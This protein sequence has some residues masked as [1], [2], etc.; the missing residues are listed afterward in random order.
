MLAEEPADIR[1]NILNKQIIN[2]NKDTHFHRCPSFNKNVKNLYGLR[3]IYDYK[4]IFE[5]DKIISDMYD[6]EFFDRMIEI[7]S[8][9]NRFFS[10]KM[11]YIFFTNEPSLEVT[12]YQFPF[13]EDNDFTKKCIILPGTFDIG[14][15]FR[16][17]ELP[18]IMR[19]EFNDLNIKQGDIYSYIKF[20]TDEKIKFKQ[21]RFN[22][23]LHDYMM[24]GYN[25]TFFEPLKKIENYYKLHKNKKLILKEISKNLL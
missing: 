20:H 2:S 10:Y 12:F 19:S 16:S 14:K 25:L 24:D 5:E 22:Y 6:Q 4:L 11:N 18:I 8:V 1:N 21:F 17:T 7:R 3:S 23:N 15:W 13:M 9:E